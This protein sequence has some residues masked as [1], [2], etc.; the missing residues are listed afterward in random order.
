MTAPKVLDGPM[1]G[2]WFL[3]CVQQVL[4]PTLKP[5]DIVVMDNLSAHKNAPVMGTIAA[6]GAKLIFLPPCSP[7]LNAIENAFAK[8]K[9][10][11]REAA[12]RTIN[13]LWDAIAQIIQTYSKAECAV[14]FAAAGDDAD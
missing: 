13:Q 11:L 7:D 1:I 6:V 8:L 4:V 5:G 9:A 10:L 12:A 14:Y 3:A 2:A